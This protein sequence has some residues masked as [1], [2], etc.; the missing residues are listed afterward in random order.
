MA[1]SPAVFTDFGKRPH[2]KKLQQNANKIYQSEFAFS[3]D[4]G[5]NQDG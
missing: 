5:R 3:Q 2:F 4:G 1:V